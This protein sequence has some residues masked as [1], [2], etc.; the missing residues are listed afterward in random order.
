MTSKPTQT[1]DSSSSDIC[2]KPQRALPPLWSPGHQHS[3][4]GSVTT[5]RRR[6]ISGTYQ[7][8]VW[9]SGLPQE[10]SES[11]RVSENDSVP[12]I[13]FLLKNKLGHFHSHVILYL[14]QI[15][16]GIVQ[17]WKVVKASFHAVSINASQSKAPAGACQR[18]KRMRLWGWSEKPC[19]VAPV[20]NQSC[21]PG[22]A[23]VWTT[24]NIV[25]LF[26]T[27][28]ASQTCLQSQ[29]ERHNYIIQEQN[30]SWR[31]A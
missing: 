3:C 31:G 1:H 26:S 8:S 28:C 10:A 23:L 4:A 21:L 15:W 29:L 22:D 14:I 30:Y 16:S 20:G 27:K 18:G 11:P 17:K 25:L 12:D 5:V 2:L 7:L 6:S 13:H 24:G 19:H 9:E